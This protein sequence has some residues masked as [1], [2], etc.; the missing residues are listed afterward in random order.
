ME[1]SV[2]TSQNNRSYQEDRYHYGTCDGRIHLFAIMDGHGGSGCAE[3]VRKQLKHIFENEC[4]RDSSQIFTS[5]ERYIVNISHAWDKKTLETTNIDTSILYTKRDYTNANAKKCKRLNNLFR[6]A[7]DKSGC[8]FI[9]LIIDSTTNHF[10]ILNIGDSRVIWKINNEIFETKDHKPS[11][12][13]LSV[14]DVDGTLRIGGTLAVGRTIGDNTP[15]CFGYVS[16]KADVYT[17]VIKRGATKFI[18]A[19]D[20]IYDIESIHEGDF[21]NKIM[22]CNTAEQVFNYTEKSFNK[23]I[24]KYIKKQVNDVKLDDNTTVIMVSL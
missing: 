23:Y 4:K 2:H 12:T 9:G 20:G 19:S 22:A 21:Y 15:E 8:T 5:F 3:F 14:E 6:G 1:H 16:H 18:L 13:Q 10:K 11:L 17:G 7:S 24:R